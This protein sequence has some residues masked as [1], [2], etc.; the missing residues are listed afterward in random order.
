MGII[1]GGI[2]TGLLTVLV[3]GLSNLI[4]SAIAKRKEKEC[5][6]S[7]NS[8]SFTITPSA[9]SLK[10]SEDEAEQQALIRGLCNHLRSKVLIDT[11]LFD[12]HQL[13]L[14][15]NLVPGEDQELIYNYELKYKGTD[16]WKSADGGFE[17]HL[18]VYDK[19]DNLLLVQ[20]D[21]V[22]DE[23]LTVG[24]YSEYFAIPY[25]A[26]AGADH[27]EVYAVRQG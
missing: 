5:Q 22:D 27:I 23:D 24:R 9:K 2:L 16:Q 13:Q 20:E 19:D 21:Y 8:Y 11:Q 1:I 17:I 7:V 6:D 12:Q 4:D 26:V 18:N 3:L 25:E 10:N 15:G 14:K